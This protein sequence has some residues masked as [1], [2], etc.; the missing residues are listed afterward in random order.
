MTKPLTVLCLCTILYLESYGQSGASLDNVTG[1]QLYQA[2]TKE[3]DPIFSGGEYQRFPYQTINGIICFGS[4]NFTF[5]ELF[6]YDRQY[7][8]VRLLYDQLLDELVTTDITGNALIRLFSPKVRSFHM[9]GADFVYLLDSG[10][11]K[12]GG[13]WQVLVNDEA[14][15][16]KKEIKIL[17]D[18]IVNHEIA[19]VLKVQT[20]YR[21]FLRNGD[22]FIPDKKAITQLFADQKDAIHAFMRKNRRRFR[23]AGF[24][25]MLTA[26]TNYYNE[27]S[28]RK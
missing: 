10:N 20:K 14:T 11:A 17:E 28:A 3:Q 24:E 8:N 4:N 13:F 18:K 21:I 26:T 1:T 12:A 16:Y 22:Y 2:A 23:K 15:L 9:H 25:T 27:L 5:G 19:P 6:Y 7:K